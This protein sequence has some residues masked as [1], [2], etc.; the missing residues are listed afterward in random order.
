M[1]DETATMT[2]NKVAETWKPSDVGTLVIKPATTGSIAIQAAGFKTAKSSTDSYRVPI[3]QADPA[4]DWVGELQEITASKAEFTE[5][6]DTFHKVAGMVTVSSELADDT[7]PDALDTISQGLGRDIAKRIDRAI[8]G[9]RGSNM[10]A[11]RGLL[12]MTTVNTVEAGEAWTNLDPFVAAIYQAEQEGAQLNAFVANPAD[13]YALAALKDADKSNRALL[14]ADPTRPTQRLISGVP[15]LASPAVAAGTVWG[16]PKDN[17]L[18][19]VIRKDVTVE[20][21]R[22]VAFT[23][24][25]VVVRALMRITTLFPHPEAIQ[26]IQLQD[27]G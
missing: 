23:R 22:S 14:G 5:D 2:T 12:D 21:D 3:V 15:L 11:P 24:D 7:N 19:I 4:A 6:Y 18:T 25:G 10:L 16:I 26:K 8:F 20:A 9:A 1:A 13:A 27:N 17:L